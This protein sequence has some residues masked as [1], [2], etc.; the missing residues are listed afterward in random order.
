M[1]YATYLTR[2]P[3]CN[4]TRVHIRDLSHLQTKH[5]IRLVDAHYKHVVN[6]VVHIHGHP[7]IYDAIY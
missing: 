3:V 1:F 6:T 2:L 7:R 4:S 5:A